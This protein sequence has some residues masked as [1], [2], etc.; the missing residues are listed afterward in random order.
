MKNRSKVKSPFEIVYTKLSRLII[1][2][3][4]L[5]TSIDLPSKVECI[6]EMIAELHKEAIEQLEQLTTRY[7]IKADECRR[8]E[9]I[10]R[11]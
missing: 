10:Q 11:R 9:R 4:Y 8:Y 2:L 5:P 6:V 3:I 7:K 1:D